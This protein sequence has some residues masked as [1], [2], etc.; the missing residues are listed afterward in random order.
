MKQDYFLIFTNTIAASYQIIIF[1]IF[2]CE[3]EST[4]NPVDPVCSPDSSAVV[5]F[6]SGNTGRSQKA[7]FQIRNVMW[8]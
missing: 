1:K 3:V 2:L 7:N 4:V 5:R 8:L 6:T